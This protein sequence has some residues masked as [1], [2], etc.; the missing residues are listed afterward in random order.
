MKIEANEEK[1]RNKREEEKDAKKYNLKLKLPIG[2]MI[3]MN[4]DNDAMT[5]IREGEES[6]LS[7]LTVSHR[8]ELE[9]KKNS[10][11]NLGFK[12]LKDSGSFLQFNNKK[13]G[14]A[15]DL[16]KLQKKE[17]G[18]GSF[19]QPESSKDR[20]SVRD[21]ISA[22]LKSANEHLLLEKQKEENSSQLQNSTLFQASETSKISSS[23]IISSSPIKA[24][25][26]LKLDLTRLK[27]DKT[28]SL[29]QKQ[30][31]IS[32][33]PPLK[34]SSKSKNPRSSNNILV[35]DFSEND[36]LLPHSPLGPNSTNRSPHN[37]HRSYRSSKSSSR[38]LCGKAR[39]EHKRQSHNVLN[40]KAA[41][42]RDDQK[43]KEKEKDILKDIKEKESITRVQVRPPVLSIPG[44]NISKGTSAFPQTQGEGQAHSQAHSQTHSDSRSQSHSQ[45]QTPN[46]VTERHHKR[47]QI[48][49]GINDL[50]LG[51]GRGKN[52]K[53]NQINIQPNTTIHQ[54]TTQSNTNNN[55]YLKYSPPPLIL[56]KHNQFVS[57]QIQ[58]K[59]EGKEQERVS[60]KEGQS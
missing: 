4:K 33:I 5:P 28:Q 43:E 15:L 13:P 46:D 48:P 25:F 59:E 36:K 54:T 21:K 35:K 57:P 38:I 47:I 18:N 16:S 31:S 29:H 40:L 8:A 56:N 27:S 14:L 50:A 51:P 22:H 11:L 55:Q 45:S 52:L 42:N 10:G 12:D 53:S 49:K 37:S 6:K 26:N 32:L 24:N 3:K 7:N 30:N 39:E 60:N 2:R 20:E 58:S 44:S 41:Q 34:S 1:N 9:T 17:K 23:R 19:H